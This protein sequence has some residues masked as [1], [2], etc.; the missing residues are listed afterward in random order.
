MAEADGI[1]GSGSY[2]YR[3]MADWA[4]LPAGLTFRDV[5]AVRGAYQGRR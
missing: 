3:V 1:V 5:T 2:T 4:K